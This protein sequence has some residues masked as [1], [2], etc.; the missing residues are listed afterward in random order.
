MVQNWD[1]QYVKAA[2][3]DIRLSYFFT[4]PITG[5]LLSPQTSTESK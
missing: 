3:D 5:H 1:V 2:V 4:N